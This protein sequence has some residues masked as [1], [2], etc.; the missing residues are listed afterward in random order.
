MSKKTPLNKSKRDAITKAV[1]QA[2][3][4]QVHEATMPELQ[5][6]FDRCFE[7][8]FGYFYDSEIKRAAF[9]VLAAENLIQVRR[10][11]RLSDFMQSYGAAFKDAGV[12][13]FDDAVAGNTGRYNVSSHIGC[14]TNIRLE[15]LWP[16]ILDDAIKYRGDEYKP[17][18]ALFQ[19]EVTNAL[20]PYKQAAHVARITKAII[21]NANS[22]ENLVKDLPELK[23]LVNSIVTAPIK[24][25]AVI[26][27]LINKALA[28]LKPIEVKA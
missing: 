27:P 11:A 28:S 12:F 15:K 7:R 4:K 22:V 8:F 5:A 3:A 26:D 18:R 19:E 23:E 13:E 10:E 20:A 2:M 16:T 24:P 1:M 9:D 6:A 14:Q 21:M 17:A 25:P